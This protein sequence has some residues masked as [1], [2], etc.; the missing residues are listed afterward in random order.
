[1]KE[2][3]KYEKEEG[4]EKLNTPV[5]IYLDVRLHRNFDVVL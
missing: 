5:S 4:K 1:M 3:K 2:D